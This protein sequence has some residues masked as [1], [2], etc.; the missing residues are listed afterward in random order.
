L[1]RRDQ[2]ASLLGSPDANSYRGELWS[3]Q[4]L[5]EMMLGVSRE[6]EFSGRDFSDEW[7]ARFEASTG[8]DCSSFYKKIGETKYSDTHEFQ[9][10]NVVSVME[11]YLKTNSKSFEPGIRYFWGRQMLL[12]E[13]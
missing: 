1:R 13:L 3:V 10:Q 9:P 2:L 11:N 6:E 8:V 4:T 12:K 7:R 5:A